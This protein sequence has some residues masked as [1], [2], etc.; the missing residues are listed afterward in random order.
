MPFG[1][2]NMH[3]RQYLVKGTHMHYIKNV[4][5]GVGLRGLFISKIMKSSGIVVDYFVDN[6]TNKQ[7]V[8]NGI[9]VIGIQELYKLKSAGDINVYIAANAVGEIVS[10]LAAGSFSGKVYGVKKVDFSYVNNL[11]ECVYPIDIYMPRLSYIEYEVAGNCNLKCKGCTHY[12]NIETHQAFGNFDN[13]RSDLKRLKQL[14]WGIKIIR[15][16]GGEP[17]LNP[18]LSEFFIAARS[19]FPDAKIQVVTNGLLIPK[20][21]DGILREMKHYQIEFDITQY[22]PTSRLRPLIETRLKESEVKY[23]MSPLVDTF[24][25]RNNYDGDSDIEESFSNCTSKGCHFLCNG[26]LAVCP[27]PFTFKRVMDVYNIDKKVLDEDVIDIYGDVTGEYINGRMSQ[28]PKTC[29]YCYPQNKLKYF[30]WES[31]V[32]VN[33]VVNETS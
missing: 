30:K 24:F 16:L 15:L 20:I 12:S 7:T 4:V 29:K 14:F 31:D 33:S 8:Y 32:N 2:K 22:L 5:F 21:S 28:A 23:Y 6:D 17:L 11:Q 26:K 13:F 1:V 3:S 27:R 9:K 25:D 18:E 10:Q 19:T